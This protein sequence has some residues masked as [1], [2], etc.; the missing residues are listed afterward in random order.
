MIENSNILFIKT[1]AIIQTLALQKGKSGEK[2]VFLKK[3]GLLFWVQNLSPPPT[4]QLTM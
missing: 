1:H 2:I 4:H 3:S